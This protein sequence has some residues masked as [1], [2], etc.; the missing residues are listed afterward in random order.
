[1][2]RIGNLFEQVVSFERLYLAAT[3]ALRGKKGKS[4]VA[5][6]YFDLESGLI[7][8]EEE[9]RNGTYRPEPYGVFRIFEPKEREICSSSV[10]DRVVHHAICNVLE[11][12][13]EKR[14]I[15][16]TYACRVGKGTHRAIERARYFMRRVMGGT[17]HHLTSVFLGRQVPGHDRG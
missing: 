15:F 17:S 16:D 6:F 11:P 10:R 2:K 5:R 4:N 7:K 13:I 1:M 3:N 12:I 14:F 9:L 8:L